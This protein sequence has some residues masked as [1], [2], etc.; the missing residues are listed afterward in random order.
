MARSPQGSWKDEVPWAALPPPAGTDAPKAPH[1]QEEGGHEDT[2]KLSL[3]A[4]RPAAFEVGRF[5][6]SRRR[7]GV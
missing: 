4:Q 1:P 7:A 2:Q 6:S 5:G 3:P